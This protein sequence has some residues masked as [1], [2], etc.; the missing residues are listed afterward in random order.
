M[1]P[2]KTIEDLIT[3]HLSLEKDLSTGKLDKT[4]FAEKSKEYSDLNEVVGVAKDYISFQ[5]EKEELEKIFNDSSVDEELKKNGRI[6]I[7][8]ITK[9]T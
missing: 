3:K 5:R 7:I 8:R 6:R 2:Q 4:L 1:I 9:S